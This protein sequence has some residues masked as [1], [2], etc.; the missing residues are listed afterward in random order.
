MFVDLKE[1]R[2]VPSDEMLREIYSQ[3]F[4]GDYTLWRGRTDKT[5][6][7]DNLSSAPQSLE[8]LAFAKERFDRT[9][10]FLASDIY[11]SFYRDELRIADFTV[12][13][14]ESLTHSQ[15]ELLIRRR[16][17]LMSNRPITD[18]LVD[19]V[20]AR[21]NSIVTNRIVPR[22]PFYVLSTLQTYEG[23]MPSDVSITS[24]G[25]CYYVM[26]L[27][28]LLK[29]GIDKRDETINICFN[30][31]EHLAFAI[32]QRNQL[33]GP[34]FTPDDFGDF[35]ASYRRSYIIRDS[36]LNR[37]KHPEYGLLS[38]RGDFRVPYMRYYFLGL[39]L[40]RRAR[41]HEAVIEEMCQRSYLSANYL[42]LLFVIHHAVDER[43]LESILLMTL[44]A[45]DRVPPATL[46]P[47]ETRRFREVVD[48][49]PAQLVS[50]DRVESE[51]R[52][53]RVLR[54]KHEEHG[55]AV[56]ESR[57]E[58]VGEVNDVYRILKN[59]EML[60]HVLRNKYGRLQRGQLQEIVETVAD[61]GLRLVNS[62]L[63]DEAEIH[64]L[65][66]YIQ[67]SRP[68]MD[69][70][71]VKQLVRF[72]SF[73]WTMMNVEGVVAAVSH[74]EIREIVTGVVRA[75]STPAYEIIGYFSA[76]DSADE[77][78]ESLGDQLER[79]QK[80]HDDP[81]VRNVLS[82][83]TQHYMNTHRSKATI[84]QRVCSLLRIPYQHRLGAKKA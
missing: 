43:V 8:F 18:G 42:T 68:K 55:G 36:V 64:E 23:F 61:G 2:G 6:V 21:V 39:F 82:L 57:S 32:Y 30:F 35:V 59:N 31:A 7:L 79:L 62:L 34:E 44:C 3:Q 26:V 29:A 52:R 66:Q 5:V 71:E 54:G 46:H 41:E 77:L 11:L 81:F 47:P 4:S 38:E 49:L 14:I 78:S 19:Q 22:Y 10:V 48:E 28:R 50:E 72:L 53:E 33:Q 25:H 13:A 17:E 75:K 20:E 58:A 84:E 9:I 16:L 60:G 37:L 69:V 83:R 12:L 70:A 65:A 73:I 80:K 56:E 15:Q 76:L 63:K 67:R 27:A 51:R 40:S 1:T 74:P 45:V 24:H